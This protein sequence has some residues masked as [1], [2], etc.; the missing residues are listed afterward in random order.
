MTHHKQGGLR[1][2]IRRIDDNTEVSVV[3]VQTKDPE[4]IAKVVADIRSSLL[5]GFYLDYPEKVQS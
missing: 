1:L 2:V 4:I 3:P 5:P